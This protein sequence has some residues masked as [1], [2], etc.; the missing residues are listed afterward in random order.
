MMVWIEGVLKREGELD[1]RQRKAWVVTLKWYLSYCRK[2]GLT[3]V[4]DRR[5]GR[6]FWR[7]AVEAKQPGAW[8][9]RQWSAALKWFFDFIE[10][11]DNA[12]KAMRQAM[13]NRHLSYRT[14]LSYLSWLRRFQAFI[15][16]VDAMAATPSQ[17]VE[18]LSHLAVK[19]DISGG[20]QTQGFNALLFFF[21]HV[22]KSQNPDFGGVHRAKT[23]RRVPIVLS[24]EEVRRL[25]NALPAQQQLAARLQYGAGLRVSELFRLRVKDLD[26]DRGQLTVRGGKWD[27]DRVTML[28][29]SLEIELRAQLAMVREGFED[30]LRDDFDGVSMSNSLARKYRGA[31]KEWIWQYVFPARTL[32]VDPRSGLRLRHHALANSYQVAIKRASRSAGIEK[33][34]SP[35]VLRHSFATH[36]LEGGADIR[37]VQELLGHESVETTQLYTHVMKKPFGLVSPVDRLDG[38]GG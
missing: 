1:E 31:R 21:R 5:V 17:V 23:R 3:E 2:L 26:F 7:E 6:Q 36:M 18:F 32:A 16:P 35:H 28:P 22:R 24:V 9:K 15:H 4:E 33:K 13:R 27:K 11:R 25:V 20:T 8:Q 37:T 19:T 12:G 34:V 30:D 10:K 38:M 14:E 29:Q